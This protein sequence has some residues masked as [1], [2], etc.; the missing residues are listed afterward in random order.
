MAKGDWKYKLMRFMQGR[1]GVDE[2]SQ[3]LMIGSMLCLL[4]D[5]FAGTGI[6]YALGTFGM[7]YAL[8]RMYSRNIEARRRELNWYGLKSRKPKAWYKLTKKRIQN[9]KTTKY[10]KCKKCGQ[11]MSVPRGVGTI[12]V[13]CPKCKDVTQHKA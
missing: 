2:F 13:T 8:F 10:F 1:Y 12:K 6:L 7:L 4:V 3:A 9:R 11:L 5:M